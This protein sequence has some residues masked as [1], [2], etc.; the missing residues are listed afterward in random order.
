MNTMYVMYVREYL[1]IFCCS[2]L[3]MD[4]NLFLPCREGGQ[5]GSERGRGAEGAERATKQNKS[6]SALAVSVCRLDVCR[7]D[8]LQVFDRPFA[9]HKSSCILDF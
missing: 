1:I 2:I 4:M 8:H 9:G 5:R 6:G 7:W 3:A